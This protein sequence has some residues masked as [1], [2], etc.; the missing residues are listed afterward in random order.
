M[1]Q[2]STQQEGKLELYNLGKYFRRRYGEILGKEYSP[3]KV[4][5]LSTDHDRA[6][7]SAQANLAGL[8]GKW[9]PIP[10]HTVPV[11][12]DNILRPQYG[13]RCPRYGELYNWF[14]KESPEA[15]AMNKKYG[16][17]FEYWAK[18]NGRKVEHIEHVFLIYKKFLDQMRH[19][20]TLVNQIKS[21]HIFAKISQKMCGKTSFIYVL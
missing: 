18:K 14:V 7:M 3:D 4:Y 11:E 9:Q 13:D 12:M 17:L 20:Q 10:V 15:E 8:Y 19:N 21:L 1:S 16:H 6:I 5:I 2:N